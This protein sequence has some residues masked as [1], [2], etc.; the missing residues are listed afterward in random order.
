MKIQTQLN[1]EFKPIGKLIED[2]R[3]AMLTTPDSAG[4][5]I[6][7]P[8]APLEMDADGALWFFTNKHSSK[9]EH[10]AQVNLSFVDHDHGTFVSLSGRGSMH[11]DRVRINALWT[12]FAKPWFPD[13]PESPDLVLLK[14]VPHTAEYWDAPNSKMVRLMAMAASQ[15]AGSPVGLGEHGTAH[16]STPTDN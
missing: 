14:V 11:D 7:R 12:S 9:I 1:S 2:I 10:L 3:V 8:M 5:L 16:R 6:S 15:L 13:G 4:A